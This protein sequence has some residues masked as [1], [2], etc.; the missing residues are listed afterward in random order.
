[1]PTALFFFA[2]NIFL[3]TF[4]EWWPTIRTFI[5]GMATG[6]VLLSLAIAMLLLSGQNKPKKRTVKSKSE[7][8]KKET[9]ESMILAKQ[10]ELMEV[11]RVSDNS[12]FR[13]AFDLSFD[14]MIEIA[15]YYFPDSKYPLYEL[16]AQEV[17]DLTF[18]ITKRIDKVLSG[19]YIARFKKY[20]ISTIVD[21]INKKKAVDNSK[22]M[23]MTRQFKISKMFSFASTVINYANPI[24]WF[25]KLALKPSTTLVIKGLCK[26]IIK[27]VGEETE[28]LY[29]KK[30]FAEPEDVAALEAAVDESIIEAAALPEEEI[31][32]KAK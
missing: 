32:E 28:K 4:S 1:M 14:L 19:K 6:F 10:T 31:Q 30:M 2:P 22:L 13:V 20:K 27:I 12:Y 16:S 26:L 24:Y 21:I 8:L 9:V 7:P 29:S 15:K 25:R 11:V 3:F 18:Y 17:I 5:L 23:K